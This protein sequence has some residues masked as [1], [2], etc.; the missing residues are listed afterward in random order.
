MFY[1]IRRTVEVQI[2]AGRNWR[3]LANLLAIWE[4]QFLRNEREGA[5]IVPI[6]CSKEEGLLLVCYCVFMMK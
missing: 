1:H 2:F 3:D 5:L 4:N 6:V